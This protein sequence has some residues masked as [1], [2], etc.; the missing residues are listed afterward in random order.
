MPG[1]MKPEWLSRDIAAPAPYYTLVLS[2]EEFDAEL[3]RLKIPLGTPYISTTHA[4]ATTS[5]LTSTKGAH[6]AI[7]ALGPWEGRSG[8]E[9][10]GLLVHEAVHV[11]QEYA[12]H[13]GERTPGSEQE[14]YAIQ[15]IAQRLMGEFARR[16]Q[17][18]KRKNA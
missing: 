3:K 8:I 2:Q 4:N 7:V 6:C 13:I 16:T 18:V 10:A 17:K 15:S 12:E 5:F 9:I 1:K 11:W 14:A